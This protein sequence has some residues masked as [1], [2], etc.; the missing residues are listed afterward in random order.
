M[1]CF[2]N[3]KINLGLNVTEKR[4]DGY[5][6]IESVFLPVNL[7]DILEFVPS[8]DGKDYFNQSGI[9]LDIDPGTNL[10]I[11]AVRILREKHDIPGL[12]IH[13][14]KAI[15]AGS[16]LGGG[17]SDAAFMLKMLN[18]EFN[19]GLSL[20]ALK[21]LAS[22]IGSDCP[23]FIEN[24]PCYITGR[25]EKIEFIDYPFSKAYI[26]IAH[27]GIH[28]STSEAYSDICPKM[29]VKN[30]RSVLKSPPKKWQ[31]ELKNDFE[32]PVFSKHPEIGNLRQEFISHRAFYTAMS[33][34][35]SAVYGLFHEKPKQ[36]IRYQVYEGE[37]IA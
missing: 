22:Q 34:S 5:H 9:K 6:N 7:C 1:I 30:L 36:K 23:F 10:I 37:I 29:P 3:A 20:D 28:V 2:P 4:S 15:P 26:Q 8:G 25:G 17:S 14:H 35:G 18:Q 33:G 11:K 24:K 19:L 21:D 12:N 16:G 31:E 32:K 27:P 13:L